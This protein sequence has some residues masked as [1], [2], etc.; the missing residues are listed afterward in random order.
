MKVIFTKMIALGGL[1][2]FIASAGSAASAQGYRDGR[3]PPRRAGYGTAHQR[4]KHLQRVYARSVHT[5]NTAAA[6]RAHWRA[7][8][9]REQVRAR[10][11]VTGYRSGS[12]NGPS[13]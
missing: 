10:R 1:C 2:A 6:R 13:W 5:G 12:W 4:I 8:A 3:Y 7:Q 11:H 9:I